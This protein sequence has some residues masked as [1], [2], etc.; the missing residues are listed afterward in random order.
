MYLFEDAADEASAPIDS[1][2]AFLRLVTFVP[3]AVFGDLAILDHRPRSATVNPDEP[4]SAFR[5][6]T[7]A[8]ADLCELDPHV[9]IKLVSALAR[10][11]SDPLRRANL[12]IRQLEQ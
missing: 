5:L 3:G 9:A 12:T 8:F 1:S 7:K 2:A 4:M 10:E 6:S 11:L